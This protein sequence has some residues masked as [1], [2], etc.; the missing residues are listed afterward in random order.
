MPLL[1]KLGRFARR[2]KY[3]VMHEVQSKHGKRIV[4]IHNHLFKNAGSTIDWILRKNFGD[5]FVDHRDD[6]SMRQGAPYLLKYLEEN[7]NV[8]ALS[9]H[10]LT[11]P[12]PQS[13]DLRMLKIMMFRHPIERVISVYNFEKSQDLS[14]F[15]NHPGVVHA[16]KLSLGDYIVWRMRKDVGSTI[17]NFHVRKALPP[18]KLSQEVINE[19]DMVLANQFL[20]SVE[21]LGLVDRFD[22]SMVL[23]EEFLR[24]VYSNIDISYV[25]QNVSQNPLESR[26]D[27]INRLKSQ[28]GQK[29]F[30]LLEMRNGQDLRL[31]K[32]VEKEFEF[33]VSTV[34]KFSD[35]LANFRRR[36]NAG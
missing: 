17:R 36:C 29:T 11:L 15:Q 23:F 27:K 20:L 3:P 28:I 25:A 7:K 4:I 8:Q 13:V 26:D 19:E 35:K 6:D 2:H 16:H 18:R 1:E 5:A 9:T 12:L 21:M 31:F 32:S 10:H 30:R 24:T 33:R 14:K 34:K 22:E